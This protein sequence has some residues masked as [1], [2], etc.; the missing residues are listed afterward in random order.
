[1][2][3]FKKGDDWYID[4]RVNGRRKR[5]NV[6]PSKTLA[7]EVLQK[8]LAERS[9]LKFFPERVSGRRTFRQLADRYWDLHGQFARSSTWKWMLAKI[10]AEL[11]DRVVSEITPGDIQKFYN[12]V[13]LRTSKPNANRYLTLIKA[14]FNKAETWGDFYGPNPCAKIKK[15]RESPNRLQYLNPDEMARLL[16]CAHPRLRPVIAC[17]LLTGMRRGEILGMTWE[18]VDF[19]RGVI[20]LPKTKAGVP[21]EVPIGPKLRTLLL[22]LGP[23]STGPVFEL[24]IIM[25][26]RYFAKALKA[27]GIRNFHFHDLRHTFASHYIMRTHDLPSLQAILGHSTPA[28]TNRYAHLSRKHLF[29]GISAFEGAIPVQQGPTPLLSHDGQQ[30]TIDDASQH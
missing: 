5:E 24:P 30:P 26:R 28:M 25:L 16:L 6:G 2:A 3:I 11:G 12:A 19:E 4:Y 21:R 1:M 13:A 8:R 27:A 10:N 29:T 15:S 22:S 18:H 23:A 14:I 17:A 9:E 7:R 20:Y